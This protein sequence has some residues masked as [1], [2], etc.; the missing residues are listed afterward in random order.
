[1]NFI[2]PQFL[3][4]LPLAGLPVLIHLFG[5][6]RYQR[7]E[8]SSLRFLQ[9]LQNDLVQRLRLR[10]IILLILRTLL[11]LLLVLAF[12]RP[13]RTNRMPGALVKRG[14]TLYLVLDN[15]A[16]MAAR[17]QGRKLLEFGVAGL[18]KRSADF[19][20]PLYLRVVCA[21]EPDHIVRTEL[22]RDPQELER[23]IAEFGIASKAGSLH[24]A[25]QTVVED[26]DSLAHASHPVFV[27]SDFQRST[28][29]QKT[30]DST[31]VP[32]IGRREDIRLLLFPVA[33]RY[34]N[35]A[36]Q[37]MHLPS[38]IYREG[39]FAEARVRVQNWRDSESDLL[40][41]LF[42]NGEKL[43][44]TLLALASGQS[45]TAALNF[46][47]NQ[48][49][50]ID[51][52]VRLPE[53][54][55][56]C[57][58]V[59]HFVLHLPEQIRILIVVNR[60][61]DAKFIHKALDLPANSP[62]DVRVV[63]AS[64]YLQEDTDPYQ[65]LIF[66]NMDDLPGNGRRKLREHLEAGNGL[67]VL[68]GPDCLPERFNRLW[69]DEFALPVWQGTRHG[70]TDSYVSIQD[71]N[72]Q[73]PLLRQVWS[74]DQ[75]Q[76][77][78]PH[79][80]DVPVFQ[81]SD[82]DEVILRYSDGS[83]LLVEPMLTDGLG[84]L[85]ANDSAGEWG[86]FPLSGFYAVLFHRMVYYLGAVSTVQESWETGDT[87]RV[88]WT[89]IPAV[90]QL[91]MESPSGRRFT[92]AVDRNRREL[93]F[94]ASDEPGIYRL[95]GAG[96]LHRLYAVNIGPSEARGDFLTG[97]ELESIAERY[98]A[99]I[100]VQSLDSDTAPHRLQKRSEWSIYCFALAL[101]AMLL[102]LYIGR[103][104]RQNIGRKSIG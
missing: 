52:S 39:D 12:A 17:Y 23:Q 54:D 46:T 92:L 51:G 19:E 50:W 44:Q 2:Y 91:R 82:S 30:G 35:A 59:R 25:L 38:R 5:R 65:V 10:Q 62:F 93:R 47:P 15:T 32:Q 102:E 88:H 86:D 89:D 13:Y 99:R 60:P 57:D 43:A 103:I 98:P 1:M 40:V 8:F 14:E 61:E 80:R 56:A 84:L 28:W 74:Q 66:S 33:R 95:S 68:P 21:S 85:L 48:S 96:K 6:N 58:N 78:K 100:A 22:I 63:G 42:L 79:F 55:L 20:F 9:Q 26:I 76:T 37:E 69:A 27:L 3:W 81:P 41:S 31:I 101:V 72:D 29:D 87:I 97:A 94:H 71:L 11:I 18:L 49:G 104:N 90:N 73:H 24:R 75:L 83:P 16:S 53:D 70:E 7:V 36:I 4:F 77:E 34:R 64:G 45:A 67:L